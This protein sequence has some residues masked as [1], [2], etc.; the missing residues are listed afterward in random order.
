MKTIKTQIKGKFLQVCIGISIVL[1]SAGFFVLSINRT[2]ASAPDKFPTPKDFMAQGTDKIGKY[3]TSM[4]IIPPYN[5]ATYNNNTPTIEVIIT[6]TETGKT[7]LWECYLGK[8][9]GKWNYQIPAN[10]F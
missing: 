1:L 4:S 8:N 7:V 9:W 5:N 6:D 3:S 2:S 10:P